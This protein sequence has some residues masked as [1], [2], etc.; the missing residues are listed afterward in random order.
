MQNY[1]VVLGVPRDA[2]KRELARAYR[3]RAHVPSLLDLGEINLVE[4]VGASHQFVVIQLHQKRNLVRVFPRHHA[5]HAERGGD[6]VAAA[7]EGELHDIFRIKII[8]VRREA[9]AG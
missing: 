6:G 1:Y 8:R 4:F 9:G 5:E 7:F 2:S 3:R